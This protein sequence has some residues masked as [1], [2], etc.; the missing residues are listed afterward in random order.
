MTQLL[1][2][3]A[4]AALLHLATVGAG[5]PHMMPAEVVPEAEQHLVHEELADAGYVE[6]PEPTLTEDIDF[7]LTAAGALHANSIAR[8]YQRDVWR[9]RILEIVGES[10][11]A[12]V[13]NLLD[14]SGC[15]TDDYERVTGDIEQLHDDALISG[16]FANGGNLIRGR[17]T[18]LGED[19][20][21]SRYGPSAFVRKQTIGT[22]NVQDNRN[23]GITITD[24][25]GAAATSGPGHATTANN[26]I[27]VT[28]VTPF[29]A[30]S[31]GLDD[32][33]IEDH[34][35][36]KTVR[37]QVRSL[38]QKAADNSVEITKGVIAS[39]IAA[40]FVAYGPDALA[41]FAEFAHHLGF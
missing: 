5:R 15:P 26:T 27:T 1:T 11:E 7:S 35:V 19:C 3:R 10:G 37:T 23:Y 30:L 33:A 41:L 21:A 16:H 14:D 38:R 34:D 17:L 40:A 29:D 32:L 36:A 25:P 24:S 8:S 18:D 31:V 4:Q 12:I 28:N 2:L 9:K 13:S 6:A 20:L 22:A 39:L